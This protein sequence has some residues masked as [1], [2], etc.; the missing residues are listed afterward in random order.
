MK[1]PF[2]DLAA[3]HRPCHDSFRAAFESFLENGHYILGEELA[4][5][6]REFARYCNCAEACGVANGL[7]ALRLSLLA[8]DVGPGDEVIVPAHTFIATWLAVSSVGADLVPA[9]IDPKTG[10][11]APDRI[12]EVLSPRT[13]AIIPVHLYGLMANMP[14]IAQLSAGR[15]IAIIEDAAQAHGARLFGQR[16]G[17]FGATGCFSFYP[18]KNLGALGDGGAVTCQDEKIAKRIQ[19]L[20]NY[21]SSQKY[22]HEEIGINSR[23]DELQAAFLRIKLKDLDVMNALRV[24]QAAYYHEAL[25]GLGDLRLLTPSN[26]QEP[27]WHLYVIRTS[28]RDALQHW[29]RN[30]EIDT[31]IHY[32]NPP[33]LQA[34]YAQWR[35]RHYPEAETFSRTCLSLPLGPHLSEAMQ[36]HVIDSIRDFFAN[37]SASGQPT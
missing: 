2:L 33:H 8:L 4:G 5:F 35:N 22:V 12:A 21:G 29:L 24:R 25:N 18:G 10:S 9:D 31:L 14:R 37:H 13:R 34:A 19:R 17:S 7:D 28:A 11:I 16:A 32:P 23:L 15:D 20:R 6:E 36:Q 3:I 1:V 27:V 30:R 26:D